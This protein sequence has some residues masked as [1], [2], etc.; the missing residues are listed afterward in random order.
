MGSLTVPPRGGL[1]AVPKRSTTLDRIRQAKPPAVLQASSAD[2][3]R[4][5]LDAGHPRILLAVDATAS[6]EAAWETAR[7]TTDALFTAIPGGLDVGLAV[8][9]GSKVHTWTGFTPDAAS[10][11][12][13]A[14]GVRCIAGRTRLVEVLES[15][16]TAERLKV[17]AY[18]GDV[19][20]EGLHDAVEAATALRLKG[21]RVVILHDTADVMAKTSAGAFNAIADASG[22][23]VIPFDAGSPARLRELLE[24]LAMLAAGGLR[25]LQERRKALPGAR[26]L[27]EYLGKG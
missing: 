17:L 18:I 5:A 24:A 1:P 25:L 11:R 15:A 20:E 9:G 22:G 12:D 19:F 21:C 26:L 4:A 16:R 2:L 10:L 6:R 13:T 27:L 23:C 8:H 7:A 14:A 3:R